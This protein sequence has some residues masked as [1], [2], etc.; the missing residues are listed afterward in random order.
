MKLIAEP[1]DG[2]KLIEPKVFEDHRGYFYESFRADTMDELGLTSSFVQHNQSLSKEVGVL[3]GLHFQ[4]PPHA[5]GKLIRVITGAVLDVVLDIRKSSATYGQSYSVELNEQNK[6]MLYVPEGFAHG[7]VTLKPN[8]L[9][10]YNCTDYYNP[11]SE[12]GIAWN[13]PKLELNW[14]GIQNPILSEKDRQNPL[15]SLFESPFE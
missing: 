5:Q 4:K 15:F 14:G 3:R 12:G 13:D 7:F 1:M 8:T 10:A 6:H 9:F 11:S 2:L